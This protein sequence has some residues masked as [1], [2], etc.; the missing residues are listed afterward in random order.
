MRVVFISNYFNHH[1]KA[2]SDEMNKL[3]GGEYFFI[4]TIP[5]EDERVN[6]GWNMINTPNYVLKNYND[7]PENEYIRGLI[8]EADVV[9]IGSASNKIISERLK[10]GKLVF[11]YSE[12]IFKKGFAW[13]K[14]PIWM[15]R[16]FYQH[17]RHKN[18][19]MLCASAY[20]AL[21]YAKTFSFINKTYKWGYFPEVK[22]YEDVDQLIESKKENSLLWVA[23]FID[24]KH[25]E[26]PIQIV[27]RLQD[28]GY[29]VHLSMRG[30][31]VL[32]NDLRENIKK[33]GAEKYIDLLG[34]MSPEEVRKYMEQAQI[35]L[36]TSDRNEGWGAVLN[37]AMNSA[38]A[39]V[40]S[41]AI[42][43]APFLISDKENGCIY[44]DGDW[45]D[46]YKKVKWL[47]DNPKQRVA[48]GKK[49]YQTMVQQ[50]NAEIAARRFIEISKMLL[51]GQDKVDLYDDGVC[52][53]ANILKD[54]W[55][56]P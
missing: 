36:F 45:D 56:K 55:Y 7:V 20:T 4:E 46:L 48:L 9:I 5:M 22:K 52:S 40:A 2:F 11:R 3:T 31:G 35:F 37:E 21:D 41:H 16:F 54:N 15:I 34:A 39:V 47:L 27:K 43:S 53:R 6:M 26:I 50:W 51:S 42:G 18:L 29:N 17:N 1:Q 33:I 10:R 32:E 19:Y 13:Y 25:P 8:N 14:W 28:D 12:R 23:R 44:K 30:N 49:A 38:C 24:W